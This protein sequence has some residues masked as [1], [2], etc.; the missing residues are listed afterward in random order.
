MA[1]RDESNMLF[2]FPIMLSGIA[3]ELRRL[4]SKIFQLCSIIFK[5]NRTVQCMIDD[6][7]GCLLLLL[8]LL[9]TLQQSIEW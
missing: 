3:E 7:I 8:L 4:C 9:Y 1:I 5:K 6:Y 2:F